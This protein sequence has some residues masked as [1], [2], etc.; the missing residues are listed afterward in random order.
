[1]SHQDRKSPQ[2]V[3]VNHKVLQEVIAWLLPRALFVGMHVRKGSTWK[4]RMLAVAALFWATSDHTTLGDRFKHARKIIKKIFREQPEP[5]KSYRGFI[6]ML[7]KWHGQLLLSVVGLLRSRMEQELHEQ[8]RI[9]GFTVFAVDGSRVETPRTTSNEEAYSAQRKQNCNTN[10]KPKRAK[11]RA[12]CKRK[13]QAAKRRKMKK[14]SAAAIAKKTSTTQI[15]LTLLWHVGTGLPWS[16]R[17]G[18]SDSSERHHL[19]EMLLEMP[20]DSLLTADAG[21]VGYDFWKAIL[22]ANRNFVIRIGANVK[23]IKQLGY[24]RERNQTV[25]LWPDKAAKK[26]MPPLVLRLIEIHDGK[27]PVYLV[28]SVLSKQRLS[29]KQAVEI[30]RYRWGIELFF[31]TFKQTFGRNKLR[32]KSAANAKLELDWSLVGLWSICL[33]GQRELVRTGEAPWQLSP[34]RA[35]KAV[36]ATM[37]DYRVRPESPDEILYSML[38]GALLDGYHRSSSKTSRGYP[39]KKQ[40]ERIASPKITHA[41]KQQINAAK[42]VKATQTNFRSAA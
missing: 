17:S 8:F 9:A 14:Q 41:L 25:Y 30:Y 39:R 18:A 42:E 4:P 3:V 27:Q 15:W 24:A 35:I 13:A 16:W 10:K 5:G 21:F 40:R 34:A 28:T 6:A 11:S 37:R 12:A 22:D 36:Q 38:A 23:L 2:Q 20:E 1:M 29:D 33:L 26:K 32:S 31:R 19:L 7:K